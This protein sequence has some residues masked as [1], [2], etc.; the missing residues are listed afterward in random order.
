MVGAETAA[1]GLQH[2]AVLAQGD[3]I[4]H[5]QVR[6]V[7]AADLHRTV[8]RPALD[9]DGG[10]EGFPAGGL[11]VDGEQENEQ[12]AKHEHGLGVHHG[13][14]L[15]EKIESGMGGADLVSSGCPIDMIIDQS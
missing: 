1:E 3:F 6:R 7:G 5:F 8:D 11:G 13:E 2:L 12:G 15:M 10:L 14:P 9:G 4:G